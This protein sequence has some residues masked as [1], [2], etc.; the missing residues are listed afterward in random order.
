M[1]LQVQHFPEQMVKN[2]HKGMHIFKATRQIKWQGFQGDDAKQ[3]E[4]FIFIYFLS[5]YPVGSHPGVKYLQK[6]LS[7]I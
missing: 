2:G 3:L 4:L 5:S 7:Q 1:K 6:E